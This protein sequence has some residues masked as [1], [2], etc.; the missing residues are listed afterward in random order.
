MVEVIVSIALLGILVLGVL[1]FMAPVLAS[2]SE[3]QKNARATMLAE[4]IDSFIASN[5]QNAKYVKIISHV[6]PDSSFSTISTD[7]V[8]QDMMG[9]FDSSKDTFQCIAFQ[10]AP[11]GVYDEYKLVM[12]YNPNVVS[13]DQASFQNGFVDVFGDSIYD[14]IN[15]IPQIEPIDNQYQEP[16]PSDPSIMVDKVPNDEVHNIG[17]RVSTKVYT[18]RD[19]YRTNEIVA[20]SATL[21]FSGESFNRCTPIASPLTNPKTP[22][23]Y[24][25]KIYPNTD[26]PY[27]YSPTSSLVQTEE[28]GNNYY[29]PET[30]IFFITRKLI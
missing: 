7:S 24:T 2:V 3:K 5:V 15:M 9:G 28:D 16:D 22:S 4:A 25:Y 21:A 17:L 29:Y 20:K 27:D 14:G 23:G 10:W 12:R 11:T 13:S 1:G 8:Y 26:L 19:C 18:N 6:P 30:Y